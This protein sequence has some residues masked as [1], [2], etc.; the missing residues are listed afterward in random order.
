VTTEEL[1][2]LAAR[3]AAATNAAL[4]LIR[5]LQGNLEVVPVVAGRDSRLR[6]T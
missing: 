3:A 2:D 5:A 1:L 4:L 6:P